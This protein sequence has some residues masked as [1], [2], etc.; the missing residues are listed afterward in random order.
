MAIA[1]DIGL[2]VWG[3]AKARWPVPLSFVCGRMI[4]ASKTASRSCRANR[5]KVPRGKQSADPSELNIGARTTI[6]NSR[7]DHAVPAIAVV[8]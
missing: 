4:I 7:L 8:E 1:A 3:S 2:V 5:S 6:P